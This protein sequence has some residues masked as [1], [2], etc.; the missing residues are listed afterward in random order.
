[1]AVIEG[2]PVAAA[3]AVELASVAAQD[4]EDGRQGQP[5]RLSRVVRR[6]R[7]FQQSSSWIDR[8][9]RAARIGSRPEVPVKSA[10]RID[11]ADTSS[12]FAR[13]APRKSA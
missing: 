5:V 2:L 13:E 11:S 3:G 12:A 1:V 4:P 10:P 8:L 7:G 9:S 6:V